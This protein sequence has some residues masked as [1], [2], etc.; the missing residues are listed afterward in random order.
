M[1]SLNTLRVVKTAD[2]RHTNNRSA[3]YLQCLQMICN[4]LKPKNRIDRPHCIVASVQDVQTLLDQ[5][6]LVC[7][8][9]NKI[10]RF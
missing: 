3:D 1:L 10:V 2:E 5:S 4:M 9:I 8:D 6:L 7:F